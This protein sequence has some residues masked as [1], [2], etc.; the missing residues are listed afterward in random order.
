MKYI[1]FIIAF[2]ILFC[3]F[4]IKARTMFMGIPV[5]GTKTAFYTKL[6]A[7]GFTY[8]KKVDGYVGKFNGKSVIV[9][10]IDNR[11]KVCAV[12]VIDRYSSSDAEIIAAYNKLVYSFR[13]SD[14][15]TTE[16]VTETEYDDSDTSTNL[17]LSSKIYESSFFQGGDP[18]K[19]V[20]F[21]IVQLSIIDY[22]IA[23][24]YVNVN[25]MPSD[26]EDL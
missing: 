18:T 14:K 16:Y 22:R 3:T 4:S 1:K 21:K 8:S 12:S 2:F 9:N 20:W 5:D 19:N 7:K 6:K 26:D 15:Y 24:K 10:A 13:N 17:F 11:G 25:N 23:I